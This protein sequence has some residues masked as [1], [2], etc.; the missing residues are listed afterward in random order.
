MGRGHEPELNR[1]LWDAWC[2]Q[3][4]ALDHTVLSDFSV[5]RDFPDLRLQFASGH[6]IET[7]GN[8]SD[9]VWWYYRDRVT[10]MCFEASANGVLREVCEPL[11]D[12]S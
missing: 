6:A 3:F 2:R 12:R 9:G 5:G 11:T 7:F 8:D 4:D 10:G 1:P